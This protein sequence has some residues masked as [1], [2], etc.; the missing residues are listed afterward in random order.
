MSMGDRDRCVDSLRISEHETRKVNHVLDT[1]ESSAPGAANRVEERL[2]YHVAE[3][4]ACT[5]VHPGGSTDYYLV[6]P[7]NISSMGLA[8]LHGC[9]VYPGSACTAALK[10][11]DGERVLVK[12]KIV[13]CCCVTGRIHDVGVTF[14]AQID[15]SNFV[16][17]GGR[18]DAYDAATVAEAAEAI[19]Q[20]AA[21]QA[22]LVE[23][24]MKVDAL[25]RALRTP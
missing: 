16:T 19:R 4:L 3:G 23:L 7:R 18:N 12:G 9:W 2:P 20:L 15:L 10:T 1:L 5:V 13:R 24:R 17:E 11:I 14:D 22:P 25:L 8:V 21:I 6:R